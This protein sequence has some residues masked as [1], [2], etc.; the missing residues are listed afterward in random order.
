MSID[1]L[2]VYCFDTLSVLINS[3]C[4]FVVPFSYSSRMVAGSARNGGEWMAA[5][6][7]LECVPVV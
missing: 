6:Q 2:L 4:L 7:V 5:A 1:V 3:S